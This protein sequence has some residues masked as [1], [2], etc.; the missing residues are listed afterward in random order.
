MKTILQQY[1]GVILAVLTAAAVLFFLTIVKDDQGNRGWKELLR[2]QSDF[3]T[4]ERTGSDEAAEQFYAQRTKPVISY[5]GG[6]G[7]QIRHVKAGERT[8]LCDFFQAV[9]AEKKAAHLRILRVETEDGRLLEEKKETVLFP[10]PGKYFVVVQATD[11]EKVT[12]IQRFA[13]PVD[14]AF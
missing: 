2:K 6:K 10:T 1:A 11:E 9:D 5:V 7:K 8:N 13:I 3:Q 4:T 14:V 12:K